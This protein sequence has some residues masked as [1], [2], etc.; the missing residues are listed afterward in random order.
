[1][2]CWNPSRLGFFGGK[3]KF[4]I[5]R[6]KREFS[7]ASVISGMHTQRNFLVRCLIM[8]ILNSNRSWVLRYLIEKIILIWSYEITCGSF[9]TPSH[10]HQCNISSPCISHSTLC[11][12]RCLFFSAQKPLPNFSIK[13][14]WEKRKL[15]WGWAEGDKRL[16]NCFVSDQFTV[17][18]Q[19]IFQ[20]LTFLIFHARP[21]IGSSMA[22]TT[23]YRFG[24]RKKGI[25]WL[26]LR[27]YIESLEII[28]SCSMFVMNLK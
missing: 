6:N 13:T 20:S 26:V 28:E 27:N 2:I 17:E 3:L 18:C 7:I 24:E 8:E 21:R 12:A 5:K 15:F 1:M 11:T 4:L 10:S 14:R 23:A 9:Q 25:S 16:K 22:E 19:I